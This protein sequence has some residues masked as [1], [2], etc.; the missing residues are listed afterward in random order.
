MRRIVVL[1]GAIGSRKTTLA[2]SLERRYGALVLRT[3]DLIGEL[4][5]AA[6]R[7]RAHLQAA[8]ERLDQET[9][10]TWL[11]DQLKR[12]ELPVDGLV[13]I[14]A[15]RIL[16]QIEAIRD[17][18]GRIVTHVHLTAPVSV[19]AGRYQERDR[20]SGE[21]ETYQEATANATEQQVEQLADHCDVLIDTALCTD[22]DVLV[23]A[24][25]R[26]GLYQT[27]AGACV[28]V[29]VGGEYGSE[30]KGNIASY[31]A[32]EYQYLV[33]V[34][35]PNA[36]HKVVSP[37]FTF[38]ALPSG[39]LHAPE[40]KVLIGPGATLRLDVLDHEVKGCGIEPGRLFI[41]PLAAVIEDSDIVTEKE[42]MAAIGSAGQGG[43]YAAA[44]RLMRGTLGGPI[45]FAHQIEE[46]KPFIRP[47]VEVLETAYGEGA[48]IMLE[49]TQ[50]AGLSLFH[51]R[52]PVRDIERYDGERN[53]GRSGHTAV[54]HS[55]NRHG[56]P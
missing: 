27:K 46:L 4:D 52:Y 7:D 43:G 51:G 20:S 6:V 48:R 40:A 35:G 26:I 34:G 14:D 18:F 39:T 13:V 42:L 23:L 45:R 5:P 25:A 53:D 16:E 10:G 31:L 22:E 3:R 49:G 33:R 28:D 11:A 37:S 36:G 9:R 38:H 8:G 15:A 47:I 50:G 44:R 32:P 55:P 12:R 56:L 1:S 29:V 21:F 24:A 54:P 30:G 17:A 19:R 2:K 41:D